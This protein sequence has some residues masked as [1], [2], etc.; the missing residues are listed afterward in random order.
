MVSSGLLL[1]D[2]MGPMCFDYGYGPFRC[3]LPIGQGRDL[4]RPIKLLQN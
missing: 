2:I 3:G 1:E 4:R